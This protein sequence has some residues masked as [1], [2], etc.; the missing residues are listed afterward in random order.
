MKIICS[1]VCFT[2]AFF[3]LGSAV[4]AI[5]NGSLGIAM[6]ESAS[7]GLGFYAGLSAFF[8]TLFKD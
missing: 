8:D 4:F 1:I 6:V 5:F 3:C 2:S 7:A